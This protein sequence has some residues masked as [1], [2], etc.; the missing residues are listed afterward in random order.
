MPPTPWHWPLVWL[1]TGT[2]D[3]G[4]QAYNLLMQHIGAEWA[5]GK[6]DLVIHGNAR[7]VDTLVGDALRA[8]GVYVIAMPANWDEYGKKAG[9]IRNTQMVSMGVAL[10]NCSW[11]V[12]V[13]AF[14][15]PNS[16]G[17]PDMVERC[18]AN[19]LETFQYPLPAA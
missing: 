7:G 10:R 6:P 17:T 3:V 15:G 19:S 12:K 11:R 2:R 5:L 13:L 8:N 1:I 16:V 18:R 4:P 14:P 9:P